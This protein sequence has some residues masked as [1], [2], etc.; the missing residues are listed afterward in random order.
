MNQLSRFVLFLLIIVIWYNRLEPSWRI[1]FQNP[2][3]NYWG[4]FQ[5]KI[6][7]CLW[8]EFLSVEFQKNCS[9]ILGTACSVARVAKV[10]YFYFPL[11]LI[12]DQMFHDPAEVAEDIQSSTENKDA[13]FCILFHGWI[14]LVQFWFSTGSALYW[15]CCSFWIRRADVI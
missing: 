14:W 10:Q 12:I 2:G 8:V 13:V 15:F 11:T 6:E 1:F 9:V 7:S 5:R 4:I 3:C